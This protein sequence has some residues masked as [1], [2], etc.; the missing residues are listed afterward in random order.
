V[1]ATRRMMAAGTCSGAGRAE[2]VGGGEVRQLL[3][4]LTEGMPEARLTQEARGALE[5]LDR[6]SR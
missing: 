4:Q 6:G 5:R 2:Q 3:R 1:A